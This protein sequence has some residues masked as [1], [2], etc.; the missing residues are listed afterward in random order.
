MTEAEDPDMI[1]Q[2]MI[3]RFDGGI[4]A[5]YDGASVK[6]VTDRDG[7]AVE[8]EGVTISL[9]LMTWDGL[10]QVTPEL[11]SER[12]AHLKKQ[13][14]A[15]AGSCYVKASIGQPGMERNEHDTQSNAHR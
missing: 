13:A 3:W 1:C 14:K 12:A 9:S 11:F 7:H 2:H 4:K 10:V 8:R 5:M 15:Q 6:Q